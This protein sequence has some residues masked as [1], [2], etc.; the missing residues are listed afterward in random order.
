[1]PSG[2]SRQFE[3]Q[4][5]HPDEK[6]VENRLRRAN[7]SIRNSLA[8]HPEALREFDDSLARQARKMAGVE[9]WTRWM[10]DRARDDLKRPPWA[11]V[12]RRAEV[13]GPWPF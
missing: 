1:L 10:R 6:S 13:S 8:S 5:Q 3:E 2:S 12:Y 7:S 4:T 11:T 9:D